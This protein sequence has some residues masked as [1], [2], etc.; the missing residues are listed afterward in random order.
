MYIF[1][2]PILGEVQGRI[3]ESFMEGAKNNGGSGA[4]APKKIFGSDY[5]ID[6]SNLKK[7]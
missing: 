5:E 1:N 2:A 7:T 3:Q 6:G 4:A